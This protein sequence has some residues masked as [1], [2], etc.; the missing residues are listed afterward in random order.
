MAKGDHGRMQKEIEQQKALAQYGYGG[1][2]G[3]PA[4]R[5][6][7]GTIPATPPTLGVGGM[8]NL[9]RNL[10]G[11]NRTFM[12]NYNQGVS[13]NLSSYDD[14]MNAYQNFIGSRQG[15]ID[16]NLAHAIAGFRGFAD[17]G[18]LSPQ[19]IQ[20]IRARAISPTRSIYATGMNEI[21]RQRALQGGYSPNYTAAMAK[22]SRDLSNQI[23]DIGVNANAAIAEMIARN[24][25]AGLEGLG[26]Y[27]SMA[28]ELNNAA[29]L[30]ALGGMTSLYGT[31]PALAATFGNQVLASG[32]QLLDAQGL[33]N[34]LANMFM[35]AR[36][37][38]AGIPGNFQQAMGN[39]GSVLGL[40][41]KIA[42]AAMGLMNPGL[43]LVQWGKGIPGSKFIIPGVG[44]LSDGFAG[45][46]TTP[47][48]G[49]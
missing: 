40:G 11:T 30:N 1:S 36:L 46:R 34:N 3:T 18:G 8:E 25:L 43:P 47:Y 38:N 22:M 21:G 9:Y 16:P 39:I 48:W 4:K 5:T 14:I 12:E 37:A 42:G 41:S 10:Y 44:D 7:L 17:T 32:N 49:G 31:T 20:D 29:M 2:P 28:D 33:Q 23:S 6:K 15:Y 27:G 24:K 35:N 26:R 13:R 19:D 45:L